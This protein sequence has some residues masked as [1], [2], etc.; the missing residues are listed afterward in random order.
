[1]TLTSIGDMA[2]S[3]MLRTRSTQIKQS[4]ATLTEEFS[5]GVT[6][7]ISGR[8][9]GDFAYLADIDRNL[10]RLTGYSVAA[11]E[12]ALF[13]AGSQA[14]LARLSDIATGLSGTLISTNLSDFEPVS[15][16]IAMQARTDLDIVISA[17]NGA[18]GGRS[19]F[20]GTATDSVPLADAD[21]LL[22]ELKTV[23]AGLGTA[24]AIKQAATDW[25]DDPAGFKAVMYSGSDDSLAP[26]Q[27]GAG[28][29]VNMWL[30]ADDPDFRD[31]LRSVALT[32]LTTDADLG[33]DQGTQNDVLRTTRDAL[34]TNQDRLLGLRADIGF[35]EARI[36]E[37]S[38]RNASARVGL[39]YAK[40]ALLEADPYETALRLEDVQ[41]QLESL[42]SVTVRTSRLSLLS[43]MG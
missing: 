11:S 24:D 23:L 42:Y 1:M 2:Q 6:S 13:S 5:T 7:D 3:L 37:A 36:E 16:N 14:G 4:I 10:T 25:F 28:Q 19:L 8:L 39:E 15:N 29:E 34:L 9:D 18:V 32:A 22:A 26:I 41:F 12:A 21:V 27:V 20:G 33:L 17:L 31:L 38:T 35:A 30:K 40:G 43:F